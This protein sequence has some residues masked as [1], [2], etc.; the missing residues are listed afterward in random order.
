VTRKGEEGGSGRR[1]TRGHDGGGR[2]RGLLHAGQL[3]GVA[4]VHGPLLLWARPKRTVIF[5]IYSKKF[6][7]KRLDSIKSWTSRTQKNSN[8]IWM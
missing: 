4:V 2:G 1:Q 7:K 3:G 5:S 6:Q 8:K